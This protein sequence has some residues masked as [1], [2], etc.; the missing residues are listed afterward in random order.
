MD[1]CIVKMEVDTGATLSLMSDLMSETTFRTSWPRRSLVASEVRLR[2]YTKDPIP[3]IGQCNV[4]IVYNDQTAEQLPLIIVKGAGPSLFG[5]NWLN[6]I[7]LNWR[8]IYHV[9]GD[10]L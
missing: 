5:R 2:S 8:E 1:D 7:V 10:S 3:V 6:H 9:H 4:N